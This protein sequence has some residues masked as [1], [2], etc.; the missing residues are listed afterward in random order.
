MQSFKE[1]NKLVNDFDLK[2][3]GVAKTVTED[4]EEEL[5]AIETFEEE[6]KIVV[7]EKFKKVYLVARPIVDLIASLPI[8]PGK[9][10]AVIRVFLQGIDDLVAPV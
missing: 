4:Q 6:Q 8:L 9:W 5:L 10:R 3:V 1:I 2:S 7:S